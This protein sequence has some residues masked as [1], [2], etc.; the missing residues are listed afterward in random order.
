LLHGSEPL[1][2]TMAETYYASIATS[3]L[4]KTRKIILSEAWLRATMT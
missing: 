4:V 3:T 2:P 1:H